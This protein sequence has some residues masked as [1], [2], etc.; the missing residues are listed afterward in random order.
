MLLFFPEPRP[1]FGER[2]R[3]LVELYMANSDQQV[4]LPAVVHSRMFEGTPG[5]WLEL[6]ALSVVAGLQ[7]AVVAPRRQQRRLALD[8][9]AWVDHGDGPVLACPVLDIS[10]AGARLWG[11]PGGAP[12]R[13]EKIRIR[14]PHTHTLIGRITWA[15][16]REV[17]V[18]Y[19]PESAEAA[20]ELFAHV[21]A[22][23]EAARV[24]WHN[25]SCPCTT[26]G[27]T[28]DP[29]HPLGRRHEGGFR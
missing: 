18:R 10:E 2:S 28:L 12:V 25:P 4:A 26:G 6:R 5:T 29:P 8:Q 13:G 20:A 23:W 16:G 27:A 14:L 21:A 7:S 17:G 24:A 11:V 15:H 19:L 3:V 9:L 1:S 22:M